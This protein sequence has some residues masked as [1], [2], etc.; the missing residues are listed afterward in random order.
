M[1]GW[2][3]VKE[4]IRWVR[5]LPG[6]IKNPP[7]EAVDDD[8]TVVDRWR[9]SR[10]ERWS[11]IKPIYWYHIFTTEQPCGCLRRWWG[12][13]TLYSWD[14]PTHGRASHIADDDDA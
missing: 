5:R 1:S 7:L 4:T 3:Y 2:R 13:Y 6:L 14:C 9:V 10:W 11:L 8:G 12:R